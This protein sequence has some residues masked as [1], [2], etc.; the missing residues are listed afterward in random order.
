MAPIPNTTKDRELVLC[1]RQEDWQRQLDASNLI[2]SVRCADYCVPRIVGGWPDA[3]DLPLLALPRGLCETDPQY[4]QLV[5]YI[6]LQPRLPDNRP[7]AD[8]YL[9]YQRTQGAERR[10][11]GRYSVGIGG[12]VNLRDVTQLNEAAGAGALASIYESV[13]AAALRE[14]FEELPEWMWAAADAATRGWAD[15]S[16]A[17][18]LLGIIDQRSDAVGSVHLGFHLHVRLSAQLWEYLPD[19]LATTIQTECGDGSF[20]TRDEI[21]SKYYDALEPWSQTVM[22]AHT[23]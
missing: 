8:T 20:A 2:T 15:A 10:L 12:H 5:P 11:S 7:M 4:R 21:Q 14:L 18:S 16:E 22:R 6:T 1:V 3:A 13:T 19:G 9:L 23:S 17:A